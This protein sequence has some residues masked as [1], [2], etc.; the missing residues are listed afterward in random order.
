MRAAIDHCARRTLGIAPQRQG[1]T[2]NRD[3]NDFVRCQLFGLQH[4][5][6]VISQTRG[7]SYGK[8]REDVGHCI[9]FALNHSFSRQVGR[10]SI[11]LDAQFMHDT[12]VAL[13]VLAHLGGKRGGRSSAHIRAGSTQPLPYVG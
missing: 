7:K 8:P 9:A 3:F 10:R 11:G 5:I 2:Q 4:R 12:A 6:P 1:F 13:V